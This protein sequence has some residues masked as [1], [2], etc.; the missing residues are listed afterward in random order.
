MEIIN[1]LFGALFLW[2]S[3][4][5]FDYIPHDLFASNLQAHGLT[6]D[7]VTFVHSYLKRRN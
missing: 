4:R 3:P 5:L 6:E 7:A 2:I 1:K